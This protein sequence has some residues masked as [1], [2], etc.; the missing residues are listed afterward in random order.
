MFIAKVLFY[1]ENSIDKKRRRCF[2]G[3]QGDIG[4]SHKGVI[5]DHCVLFFFSTDIDIEKKKTSTSTGVKNQSFHE[6][7]KTE[8][9]KDILFQMQT[10]HH[11][12][13]S[14]FVILQENILK[15]FLY[16][17][18]PGQKKKAKKNP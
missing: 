2:Q 4:L 10:F 8:I 18:L 7:G 13:F 12:F 5:S 16:C 3:Y 1:R 17:N 9:A 14:T 6:I 15:N 11:T